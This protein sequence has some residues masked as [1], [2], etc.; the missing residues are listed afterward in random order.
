MRLLLEHNMTVDIHGLFLCEFSSSTEH[1]VTDLPIGWCILP[2]PLLITLQF[3][4]HL[5]KIKSH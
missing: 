1:S 5:L 4:I 2:I 3:C